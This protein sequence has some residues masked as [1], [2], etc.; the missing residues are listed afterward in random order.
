MKVQITKPEEKD[1]YGIQQ[2]F[3]QCWLATYPNEKAGITVDDIEHKFRDAFTEDTLQQRTTYLLNLPE[4]VRF[5]IVK[6][7]GQVIGV[8]WQMKKTGVN[9]LQ[10][11]YILPYYQGKGIGHLLWKDALDY[12]GTGNNIMA[13]VATYNT[14]AIAF[15]KKLGFVETRKRITDERHRMKSGAIITDL[16]MIW[17]AA[18]CNPVVKS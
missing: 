18:I 13:Q 5:T 10:A 17:P 15:Y 7:G 8:C 1:I 9:L 4:N 2:V 12:F 11:L 16:E 3:Y 6:E 14:K